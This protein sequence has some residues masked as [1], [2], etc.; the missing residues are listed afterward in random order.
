MCSKRARKLYCI[1]KKNNLFII[2]FFPKG[3]SNFSQIAWNIQIEHI[4]FLLIQAKFWPRKFLI[5]KIDYA[6]RAKSY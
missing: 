2:S 1:V 4:D 3:L 6:I 5:E